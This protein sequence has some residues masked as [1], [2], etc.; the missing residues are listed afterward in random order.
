MSTVIVTGTRKL[1]WPDIVWDELDKANPDVVVH[2]GAQGA[3]TAAHN[4]C[5]RKGRVSVTYFPDYER[6]GKGAPLNRNV[7]MLKSHLQATVLA[8][9]AQDSR[10]TRFTIREAKR[11]GMEVTVHELDL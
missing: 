6:D 2:G 1:T 7:Q 5:K 11:L 3:D 9:P 8:F 10:G 4:W